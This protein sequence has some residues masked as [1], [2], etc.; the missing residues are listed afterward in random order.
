MTS[1]I[2]DDF[3]FPYAGTAD[4]YAIGTVLPALAIVVTGMRIHTRRLQRVGLGLDDWLITGGLVRLSGCVVALLNP[5]KA[6]KGCAGSDGNML[7]LW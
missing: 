6:E 3:P 2:R 5:D 4:C 7:Y 1:R